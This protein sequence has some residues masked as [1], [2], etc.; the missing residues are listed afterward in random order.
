[1]IDLETL[2][3]AEREVYAS[4][5]KPSP[6]DGENAGLVTPLQTVKTNDVTLSD[7]S[8]DG[9]QALDGALQAA[10]RGWAVFPLKADGSKK[11]ALMGWQDEA[12][13]DV[14]SIETWWQLGHVGFG[15]KCG[16]ESGVF[17]IDDDRAKHDLPQWPCPVETFTVRSQSGK[18]FHY[19]FKWPQGVDRIKSNNTG[20]V[21]EHVDVK[22]FGD[23]AGYTVCWGSFGA[24]VVS[25]VP[26][27]EAPADLLKLVCSGN[28][29]AAAVPVA[30]VPPAAIP[31]DLDARLLAAIEWLDAQPFQGSDDA[32]NHTF[33]VACELC[34]KLPFV[35][36]PILAGLLNEWYCKFRVPPRDKFIDDKIASAWRKTAAYR[37]SWPGTDPSKV[38]FSAA[39]EGYIGDLPPIVYANNR[40]FARQLGPNDPNASRDYQHIASNERHLTLLYKGDD[41]KRAPKYEDVTSAIEAALESSTSYTSES[42]EYNPNTRKFVIG[43]RTYGEAKEDQQVE[44]WLR[45]LAGGKID[46]L[47]QQI[48]ACAPRWLGATSKAT[49]IVGPKSSGKTLLAHGLAHIWRQKPVRMSL[50]ISRFNGALERCPIV[51]ADETLPAELTG[52]R[53]RELIAEHSHTIELKGKEV[54]TI[55]GALRTFLAV[56]DASILKLHGQKS[57]A[58]V[59]AI[60][61]R[62]FIV[63]VPDDDGAAERAL[64]PLLDASGSVADLDRIAGHFRWIWETVAPVSGRFLGAPEDSEALTQV[65]KGEV[66]GAA[67]LWELVGHF[68]ADPQS[69]VNAYSVDEH[70]QAGKAQPTKGKGADWARHAAPFWLQDD[71]LLVYPNALAILIGWELGTVQD[72]LRPFRI[73]KDRARFGWKTESMTRVSSEPIIRTWAGWSLDLARVKQ[74]IDLESC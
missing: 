16:P 36:P 21:A 38:P 17:V 40:Y 70:E 35:D 15:V 7:T 45:A 32:D 14:E 43:C 54:H 31:N 1:M 51:L 69:W 34:R 20:K 61:T 47:K 27:A 72:A 19:Y 55:H 12:T 62:L 60:A 25:D 3:P 24:C 39:I 44:G 33:N 59:D 13:T 67:A 30:D 18:G 71:A 22:A 53:F 56:N 37:A 29:A 49:A 50:A 48:A 5:Q 11:P 63:H 74:A 52:E 10:A 64:V 73:G 8:A 42:N 68:V 41:G 4:V 66:A 28:A 26:A 2:S 65:L 23:G 46:G 6:A 9:S 57:K 58:D